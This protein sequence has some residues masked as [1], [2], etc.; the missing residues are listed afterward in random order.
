MDI[1]MRQL[2]AAWATSPL[3]PRVALSVKRHWADLVNQWADDPTIPLFVRKASAGRG[4]T[5]THVSGRCLIP[6]DNSPAVWAFTNALQG[7]CPTIKQVREALSARKIP[8]EFT[9]LGGYGELNKAGWKLAHMQPV[10]LKVRRP[11]EE[12]PLTTLRKHFDNFLSPANMFVV[13]KAWPCLGEMPAV[14]EAIE[15]EDRNGMTARRLIAAGRYKVAGLK[16][17]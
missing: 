13:P 14:I 11:L 8:V 12:L 16:G 2:A 5:L 7:Q 6:G 1:P 4:R 10:G 3:R 15:N 9:R 17:L